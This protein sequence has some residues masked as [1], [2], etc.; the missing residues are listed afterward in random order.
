MAIPAAYP[1]TKMRKLALCESPRRVPATLSCHLFLSFVGCRS[2][3]FYSFHVILH[4]SS[5]AIMLAA[6]YS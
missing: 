3:F 4:L 2:H 6:G 1:Y 5:S